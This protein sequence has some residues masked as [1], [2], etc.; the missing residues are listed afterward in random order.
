MSEPAFQAI[1][2]VD[3][4]DFGRRAHP[5]QRELRQAM[6]Q[7]V[8]TAL[9]DAGLDPEQIHQEDRGDG[10]VM[11]DPAAQTLRLAGPFVRA[12]D[13]ALQEK[14]RMTS[15]E[16]TMRLRVALHHGICERD[17]TGW[18]GDPINKTARLVDVP[19]LKNTLKAADEARMVLI[20]SDEVYDG[21]IRHDYRSIDSSAFGRIVFDAKELRDEAAW[22]YVPG[23]SYPPVLPVERAEKAERAEKV[24]KPEAA[25]T[26][27]S[28]GFQFNNS[29]VRVKGDMAAGIKIVKRGRR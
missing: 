2:I 16:A 7:V 6:Y 11:I 19:D 21:V 8:R 28:G 24:R 9:T 25:S 26:G 13:D 10:I 15:A 20:V 12:L 23:R 17:E 4:E 1:L 27:Q 29:D 18:V 5:V 22:I 3:I 14:A